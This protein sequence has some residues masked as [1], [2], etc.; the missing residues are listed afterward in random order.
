MTASFDLGHKWVARAAEDGF[1][2]LGH[3]PDES[4]VAI[5]PRDEGLVQNLI[6][7]ATMGATDLN[8]G[9]GRM[10]PMS[11]H[12]KHHH[13][14]GAEFYYFVKGVCLMHIDGVDV[15]AVPGTAIYI[16]AG[17]VHGM[18]NESDE[19]VELVYGFNRGDYTDV[20]LVYDE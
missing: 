15:E 9:V 10:L 17:A 19:I 18:R 12:I 4:G 8:V 1:V 2:P 13:P 6:S 11:C 14:Y 7:F 5:D 3:G 20:G 16:P